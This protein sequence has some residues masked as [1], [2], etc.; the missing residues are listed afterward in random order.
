MRKSPQSVEP[1]VA[2]FNIG[3]TKGYLTYG[4]TEQTK[5]SFEIKMLQ[6]RC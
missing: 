6:V 1:V 5:N 4:M 2:E 3:F